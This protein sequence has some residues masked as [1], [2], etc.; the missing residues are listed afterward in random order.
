MIDL[1]CST[2][3]SSRIAVIL[4]S[5]SIGLHSS[6][7]V[8]KSPPSKEKVVNK[9]AD[10]DT[11]SALSP[12][13]HTNNKIESGHIGSASPCEGAPAVPAS[14]PAAPAASGCPFSFLANKL[15]PGEQAELMKKGHANVKQE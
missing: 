1:F 3:V 10:K 8:K 4:V 14:T 13:S 12:T 5:V 2:F 6:F 15:S 7:P 11:S 9:E